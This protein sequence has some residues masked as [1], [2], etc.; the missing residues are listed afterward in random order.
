MSMKMPNGSYV[1]NV[2]FRLNKLRLL[3]GVLIVFCPLS[4]MAL[5]VASPM[6]QPVQLGEQLFFDITLSR[7]GTVSCAS[8]HQPNRAYADGRTV[9]IGVFGQFGTRNAPSLLNATKH[10]Q[11]MWDGRRANLAAQVLHPFTTPSEHGLQNEEELLARVAAGPQ[12][13][14]FFGAG[15]TLSADVLSAALVSYINFI[16]PPPPVA[17]LTPDQEKG[18]QIFSDLGCASCHLPARHAYT[19]DLFHPSALFSPTPDFLASPFDLGDAQTREISIATHDEIAALGR[20]AVTQ[21]LTELGAFRTPSLAHVSRTAPYFHNGAVA[22]LEDAVKLEWRSRA[23][24]VLPPL[25][26]EELRQL[27]AFLENL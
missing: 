20:F 19:D 15:Q 5:P 7:D 8:C 9:S 2:K 3:A 4:V 12:Y 26:P 25:S 10:T 21:N 27:L 11:Q 1:S 16:T 24:G 18:R 6:S 17:S 14:A 13:Q 23:S 22:R